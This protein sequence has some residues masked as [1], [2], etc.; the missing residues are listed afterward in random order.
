MST[1]ILN[2]DKKNTDKMKSLKAKIE[3]DEE[4]ASVSI[5]VL[6][7]KVTELSEDN[8]VLEY[9]LFKQMTQN[10]ESE[11]I[12]A[13]LNKRLAMLSEDKSLLEQEL[14]NQQ[15]QIQELADNLKQKTEALEELSVTVAK[16]KASESNF[17]DPINKMAAMAEPVEEDEPEIV[18]GIDAAGDAGGAAATSAVQP[19]FG[20]KKEKP[21]LKE[22]LKKALETLNKAKKSNTHLSSANIALKT[23]IC[24]LKDKIARLSEDKNQ[25]RLLLEEE[26]YEPASKK[27]KPEKDVRTCFQCSECNDVIG[28][29]ETMK[30][31]IQNRHKKGT[32]EAKKIIKTKVQ[33]I[34]YMPQYMEIIKR[35]LCLREG[36]QLQ[37]VPRIKPYELQDM[38]DGRDFF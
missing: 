26:D 38:C 21:A 14:A 13:N 8:R 10:R 3:L 22:M 19:D 23:T 37:E 12:I 29:Y 31:H 28:Y 2:L 1:R 35:R 24:E 11:S 16:K 25:L 33:Q 32:E 5:T 20:K 34:A 18:T 15:S 27:A 7:N 36:I 6:S 9:E 4:A 17:S 30:N